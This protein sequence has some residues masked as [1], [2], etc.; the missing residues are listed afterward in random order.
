VL[1]KQ[2]GSQRQGNEEERKVIIK[3]SNQCKS[4]REIVQLD[5]PLI[6]DLINNNL[7]DCFC[8]KKKQ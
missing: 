3:L 2:N 8:A 1:F 7:I 5:K 6:D 4:Y